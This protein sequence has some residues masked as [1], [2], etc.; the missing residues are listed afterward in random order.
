MPILVEVYNGLQLLFQT[1][2]GGRTFG[3]FWMFLVEF[4]GLQHQESPEFMQQSWHR[5]VLQT[6]N[7]LGR[8]LV[9]W[10]VK[11]GYPRLLETYRATTCHIQS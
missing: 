11:I 6:L 3:C 1:P 8:C 2:V 7:N 10:L 5:R 9:G 4:Y